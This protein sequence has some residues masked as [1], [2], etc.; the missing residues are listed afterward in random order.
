MLLFFVLSDIHIYQSS[1]NVIEYL[2]EEGF[3]P[4][5]SSKFLRFNFFD[6]S[7]YLKKYRIIFLASYVTPAPTF[8]PTISPFST[9]PSASPTQAGI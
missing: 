3:D 9:I 4:S 7:K 1:Q 5:F 6:K 2:A 8:V